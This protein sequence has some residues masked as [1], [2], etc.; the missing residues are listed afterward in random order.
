ML[1]LICTASASPP[2]T[3]QPTAPAVTTP[4]TL[5]PGTPPQGTITLTASGKN[6]VNAST[7]STGSVQFLQWTCSGTRSN[8]VDVTL[9][10]N[11][12]QVVVIGQGIATGKTAWTV[13]LAM[14]SGGYQLRVTSEDDSR[15]EARQSVSVVLTT[16]TL[17]A[18]RPNDVLVPGTSFTITWTYTG[19]PGPLTFLLGDA[20]AKSNA[21]PG[22]VSPAAAAAG[23]GS[24]AWALPTSRASLTQKGGPVYL[25][26]RSTNNPS[27]SATSTA[28]PVGCGSGISMCSGQCVD[29]QSDY[30]NCGYCGNSCKKIGKVID[31]D[32]NGPTRTSQC[33]QGQCQ[34]KA[35]TGATLCG[36]RCVGLEGDPN[37]CGKCGNSCGHAICWMGSCVCQSPYIQCG[38]SCTDTTSD[39]ANCGYCGNACSAGTKC[40]Q[41][42]CH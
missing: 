9:W 7:W 3:V 2:T 8:L 11:N 15:I 5:N 1:L 40:Q 6:N 30:L 29:L 27:I 37:N 19:D 24:A 13:P 34:C 41:S 17:T 25:T 28:I 26:V 10:Q 4:R 42:Y 23:R 18:P 31:S 35:S 32:K 12:R 39:N 36:D 21:L 22:T 14:A 33:V 20:P 16:I 38:P